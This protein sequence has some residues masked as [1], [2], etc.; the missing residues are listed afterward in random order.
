MVILSNLHG[1]LSRGE[2][3][4]VEL[5][6]LCRELNVLNDVAHARGIFTAVVTI[7]REANEL[8][9]KEALFLVCRML[10][11]DVV[12]KEKGRIV[13]AVIPAGWQQEW[14][15]ITEV[16]RDLKRSGLV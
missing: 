3:A 10:D 6:D 1:K 8:T 5:L 14:E 2:E 12:E 11:N 9:H 13:N 15:Y 4:V 16:Y 7:L